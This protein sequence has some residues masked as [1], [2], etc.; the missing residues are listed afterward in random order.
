M[1]N[2]LLKIWNAFVDMV[3]AVNG[4][5]SDDYYSVPHVPDRSELESMTKKE[6]EEFAEKDFGVCLDVR[7]K[8]SEMIDKLLSEL[9]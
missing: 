4:N 2:F 1:G 3:Q 7:K 6:I 8:K 9:D 5:P